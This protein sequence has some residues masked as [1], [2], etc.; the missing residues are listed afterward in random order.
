MFLALFLLALS[1]L[2][3]PAAQVADC[4]SEDALLE[5]IAEGGTVTFGCSGL[6]T[7]RL[8][9]AIQITNTVVIDG[10]GQNIT[11]SPDDDTRIFEV[12]TNGFLTLINVDLSGGRDGTHGGGAIFNRGIVVLRS[13]RVTD[14]RATGVSGADGNDSSNGG[15]NGGDG[16]DGVHGRRIAGGAIFNLGRF[17]ATEC[18]F[19]DN[20]VV[21]GDGGSGGNA[22]DGELRGGDGGD[23]G[24][25]GAAL[26]GAIYNAGRLELYRCGFDS[27]AVQGGDAGDGGAKGDGIYPGVDGRGGKGGLAAGGAVFS[28]NKTQV[29]ILGCTFSLNTVLS[30]NSADGGS[31]KNSGKAGPDGPGAF[32]GGV[33]NYGSALV[34]NSTFSDNEI[35]AGNGGDGDNAAIKGGNGG[36]GGSAWG[37]SYY[38]AGT[39]FMTNCTISGGIARPGTN[40]LAG[41]GAFSGRNGN[42]GSTRGANISS[43]KGKFF[44]GH[45]ILDNPGSSNLFSTNVVI[46]ITSNITFNVIGST[47]ADLAICRRVITQR[48]DDLSTIRDTLTCETND[49]VGTNLVAGTVTTATTNTV[50]NTV[51]DNRA[52]AYGGIKDAGYNLSSD[53]SFKFSKRS[54][55]R[56]NIPAELGLLEDNDGPTLTMVPLDFSEAIDAGSTNPP[57]ATDQRGG[58][59]PAGDAGDIGAVEVGADFV[60]PPVIN[61]QPVDNVVDLGRDAVFLVVVAGTAPFDYQWYHT[62]AIPIA[63]ATNT[64]LTLPAVQRTN[65]GGYY[66]VVSNKGGTAT[67]RTATLT[68]N[69]EPAILGQPADFTGYSGEAFTLSFPT[70]GNGT[71][72][73]L[74]N[75]E[76]L[77]GAT[78]ASIPF[79][80]IQSSNSGT[81]Q[82][83]A[84]NTFGSVTSRVATVSVTD[85]IGLVEVGPP[86]TTNVVAGRTLTLS[87]TVVGSRPL[88]YQWYFIDVSSTFVPIVGATNT[89][90]TFPNFQA[91]NQ[92]NYVLQILNPFGEAF[93]DPCEVQLR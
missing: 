80:T 9:A 60:D 32:G 7:I 51:V 88:T 67:S 28:T 21:G 14:N 23:G 81:Y 5:A 75:G 89:V 71:Y 48:I 40:G 4:G 62:P 46:T 79:A 63:G 1:G 24:S 59:R 8:S 54:T 78:A 83:I 86:A 20:Q 50:R 91:A 15:V 56:A 26:G 30:G 36:N 43:A 93:T 61:T 19:D 3:L 55:S 2:R 92:G 22:H 33:C 37:G 74:F 10:T 76:P 25:G 11:L 65:A 58:S 17:T 57:V 82:A 16:R 38:N 70:S 77:A 13:C 85:S 12:A 66:V 69:T 44:L 6:T 72:T 84:A 35:Q 49:I 18:G 73:W 53:G 42:R 39:T 87:A 34:V 68:V 64:I 29:V 52:N 31:S 41:E 90:L 47:N 45:T 27:N